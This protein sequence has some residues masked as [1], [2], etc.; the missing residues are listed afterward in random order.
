[1]RAECPKPAGKSIQPLC[2]MASKHLETSSGMRTVSTSIKSEN[3]SQ[4][5]PYWIKHFIYRLAC[6]D[7]IYKAVQ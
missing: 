2:P 6:A 4:L 5:L 1:M 3:R 7:G